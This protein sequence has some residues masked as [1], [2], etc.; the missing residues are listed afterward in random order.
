[1]AVNT[2][3]YGLSQT[4]STNGPDGAADPPSS[5]DNAIQNAL[6]FTAML[7]DGAHQYIGSIAGTNTITGS[8][9]PAPSAYVTGQVYRFIVAN[10]NTG[11][12]TLNV[13]SV[14]AKAITKNGTTALVAGDLL[15]GAAVEVVYDGTQ[16]QLVGAERLA[17]GTVQATTSGTSID[18]TGIPSWAKKITVSFSGVSTNGTSLPIVQI[19]DSGG[20]ETSGYSGATAYYTGTGNAVTRPTTGYGISALFAASSVIHGT[21]TLTL[22]DA[23]TNTWAAVGNFG[24]SD[25]DAVSVSGGSKSLSAT[26]DRI[27]I[28]TVG[29]AN[30]FDAGKVNITYEG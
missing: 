15:A 3:L 30:T 17:S 27:R 21:M 16:F 12:V 23:A 8:L 10:T 13:N 19:G 29:G 2:S 18:F 14:G 24:F 7:R 22:V 25:A 9:S 11:A 6:A 4:A 5:L 20:V 26:L 1:M 28:T